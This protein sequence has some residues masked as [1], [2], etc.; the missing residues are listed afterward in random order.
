MLSRIYSWYTKRIAA[1]Y[2]KDLMSHLLEGELEE[3][4]ALAR[5]AHR[6]DAWFS[7]MTATEG[8]TKAR[9][10]RTSGSQEALHSLKKIP[11][12]EA[13]M[14]PILI[15]N[16]PY[17]TPY[18]RPAF[19]LL[20][21][22][23]RSSLINIPIVATPQFHFEAFS[24]KF[25]S[26]GRRFV[27]LPFGVM[28][29]LRPLAEIALGFYMNQTPN[30]VFALYQEAL[31]FLV[32]EIATPTPAIFA[33]VTNILG[34]RSRFKLSTVHTAHL[35]GVFI[36]LHELGHAALDHCAP[37]DMAM[38]NHGERH[39]L[40]NQEFRADEFAALAILR[41]EATD[42]VPWDDVREMHLLCICLLFLVLDKVFKV[43]EYYPSFVERLSTLLDTF[44]APDR[45]RRSVSSTAELFAAVAC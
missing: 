33:G 40:R 43:P 3:L 1:Q 38:L 13:A 32:R 11:E 36:L 39:L 4:V 41:T 44:R 23:F 24:S 45:L 18:R 25:T 27:E 15:L 42:S 30:A 37:G 26:S 29:M 5:T 31:C 34:K 17:I 6:A 9:P 8:A 16:N 19:R 7:V 2:A 14:N 35:M 10:S 21:E 22:R 20:P 12:W 28:F